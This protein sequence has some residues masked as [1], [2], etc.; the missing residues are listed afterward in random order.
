M[1]LQP[2][3]H[4][5]VS[6]DARATPSMTI[7][8]ARAGVGR[9]R[10]WVCST[11]RGFGIRGR[12]HECPLDSGWVLNGW[13]T[14]A[15]P[16]NTNGTASDDP[17]SRHAGTSAGRRRTAVGGRVRRAPSRTP[18][19]APGQLAEPITTEAKHELPPRQGQL[20]DRAT[21]QVLPDVPRC[22]M[23]GHISDS[24]WAATVWKPADKAG[25]R[26]VGERDR[27]PGGATARALKPP[28]HGG[29]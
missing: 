17:G 16:S 27:L 3:A 11:V 15:M 10:V 6:P 5:V 7:S 26:P 25:W 13:H 9:A 18:C 21:E 2:D 24:E 29:A 23:S 20:V 1:K 4:T 28:C 19:A 14:R 22:P 12:G 8:P